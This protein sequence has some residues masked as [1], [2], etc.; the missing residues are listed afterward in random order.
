MTTVLSSFVRWLLG[1]DPDK[2]QLA[3]DLIAKG[4]AEDDVRQA[5]NYCPR[6]VQDNRSILL[7]TYMTDRGAREADVVKSLIA[8]KGDT[9]ETVRYHEETFAKPL[10][11]RITMI[12]QLTSKG[13]SKEEATEV[14]E[15]S[16]WNQEEAATLLANRKKN[17]MKMARNEYNKAKQIEASFK[18]KRKTVHRASRRSTKPNRYGGNV[19]RKHTDRKKSQKRLAAGISSDSSDDD[20]CAMD[21]T[22]KNERIPIPQDYYSSNDSSVD[23]STH[24]NVGGS[25]DEDDDEDMGVDTQ[26]EQPAPVVKQMTPKSPKSKPKT[27][28]VSTLS[29]QAP[30]DSQDENV[31]KKKVISKAQ[32]SKVSLQAEESLTFLFTFRL[33]S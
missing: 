5:L 19:M 6:V 4:I 24:D 27:T 13:I 31:P 29:P 28:T 7:F 33:I 30:R 12:K 9:K 2:S 15:L 14:L 18:G 3:E 8:C 1:T 20:S 21:D 22:P 10:R 25:D 17:E 16:G 32:K 11:K 26:P 23:A